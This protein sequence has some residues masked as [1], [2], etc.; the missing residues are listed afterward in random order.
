VPMWR[1]KVATGRAVSQSSGLKRYLT[2]LYLKIHPDL[3]NQHPIERAVNE[4]SFQRLQEV[5]KEHESTSEDKQ[6]ARPQNDKLSGILKFYFRGPSESSMP[7]EDH[8]LRQTSVAIRQGKLG[9]AL[10]ELFVSIG[11]DPPPVRLLVRNGL[12]TGNAEVDSSGTRTYSLSLSN[13]VRQARQFNASGSGMRSRQ[14][15]AAEKAELWRKMDSARDSNIARLVIKRSRGVTVNMGDGL[16]KSRGESIAISRLNSCLDHCRD[17]DLTGLTITLDGG[18][19]VRLHAPTSSL[20]LGLCVAVGLWEAALRAE[21]TAMAAADRRRLSATE[22]AA[23]TSIGVNLI[24]YENDFGSQLDSRAAEQNLTDYKEMLLYITQ[25]PEIAKSED[26]SNL[27]VMVF[28]SSHDNSATLSTDDVEGL[29]KIPL[30]MRGD[31]VLRTIVHNGSS[32]ANRHGRLRARMES[33]RAQ[34]A[35]LCRAL[36][37]RSIRRADDVNDSQWNTA[38]DELWR[39]SGRIGGLLDRTDLVVGLD[40]RVVETG[41]VQ[42]P[43]NFG[44]VLPL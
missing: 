44:K 18:F 39:N 26:L 4:S 10:H 12:R 24:F 14:D 43:W 40:A 5:L 32:L 20:T 35:R 22:H 2:R 11:L 41:E 23:A 8:G 21:A 33:E 13:L 28:G 34:V 19:D 25:N 37:I 9:E 15:A 7:S 16:P 31:E 38:L 36:R 3:L 29:I 1:R 27:S 30:A 17:I 42:V 6:Y